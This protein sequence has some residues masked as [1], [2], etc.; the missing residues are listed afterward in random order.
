MPHEDRGD[1]ELSAAA[2]IAES[3]RLW[4]GMLRAAK[5]AREAPTIELPDEA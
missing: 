1:C 4:F 2:I 5:T 3:M